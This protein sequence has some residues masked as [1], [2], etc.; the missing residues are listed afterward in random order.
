M[1]NKNILIIGSGGREHALAWKIKQSPEVD[2]IFCMLGNGGTEEIAEN[3]KIAP[4]DF[5]NIIQFVR[6][7]DIN[8]TIVGPEDPL[9][10]GIVDAF[11]SENLPIFG[12]NKNVAQLEGSKIFAKDFM[13]RHHIPTADFAK[14][15][16]EI[17][18]RNYILTTQYPLVVKLDG[19]A[20]GKGVMI[21]PDYHT[22]EKALDTIFVE[23]KFGENPAV[24]I[25][26]FLIGEEI[27][28]IALV[29]GTDYKLFTPSQDHKARFEGDTGQNTGGMGA[30]APAPLATPNLI[31]EIEKIVILPTLDGLKKDGES[32]LGFLYFGLMMT[33]DGPKILE[34]NCRL[35]DPETQ[36]IL[37]Q[38]ES[39]LLDAIE[40]ALG[41]NL[42]NCD[43]KLAD[44]Y[45]VGIVAAS[46]GYPESYEKGKEISGLG[47]VKNATV[48]QAGT[49]MENGKLQTSGGR[50][51]LVTAQDKSLKNA[52]KTAYRELEKISFDGM[53][54]RKDIAEKGIRRLENE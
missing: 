14:F 16:E 30:Y 39:D 43:W 25:E 4:N 1:K 11:E 18:V 37:P 3:V 10:N 44:D 36:V 45:A 50:V 2:K 41:G 26:D 46:D 24:V 21:C 33:V 19:L 17:E 29:S 40:F 42:A 20:A 54:F 35:G 38:L 12:P 22:A 52:Q 31:N 5:G 8:L 27:S 13:K 15:D 9:V 32:Y 51:L 53:I 49:K 48:F 6:E 23:Q 47:L 7:N 28:I 34:Y